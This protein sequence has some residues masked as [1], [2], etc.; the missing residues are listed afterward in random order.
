MKYSLVD[1]DQRASHT[2][3]AEKMAR[4]NRCFGRRMSKFCADV[5]EHERMEMG[6]LSGTR[7]GMQA[8]GRKASQ[9]QTRLRMQVFVDVCSHRMCVFEIQRIV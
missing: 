3:F 1:L 9:P 5:E 7:H 4:M 6:C 2:N 8:D